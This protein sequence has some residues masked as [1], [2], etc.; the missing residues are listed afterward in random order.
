MFNLHFTGDT[1]DHRIKLP[2]GLDR[3]SDSATPGRIHDVT[4]YYNLRFTD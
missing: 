3:S 1:G 4:D 2:A